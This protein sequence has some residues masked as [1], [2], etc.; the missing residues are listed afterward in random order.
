M[1]ADATGRSASAGHRRTGQPLLALLGDCE[2]QGRSVFLFGADSS[3]ILGLRERVAT[4]FPG[5]LIAGICDADFEG[6]VDAA[7][8]AHIADSAADVIVSDLPGPRFRAF[9]A[10]CAAAGIAGETLNL[11]ASF[12]AALTGSR[13]SIVLAASGASAPASFVRRVR[14]SLAGLRFSAI[15]LAQVFRELLPFRGF[16]PARRSSRKA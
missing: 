8:L 6:P 11:P 1:T 16:A 12:R 4:G 7:I 14:A 10:S 9:A 5:L 15:V 3:T 2:R 13:V